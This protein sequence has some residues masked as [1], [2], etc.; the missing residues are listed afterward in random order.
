MTLKVETGNLP[1]DEN[2]EEHELEIYGEEGISS[3]DA[4]FPRWLIIT[5]I[6]LPIWG[7]CT[8]F[9]YFNGSHGWLDPSYWN[10]L[11]KAALTTYLDKGLD[12][13]QVHEGVSRDQDANTQW[14]EQNK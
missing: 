5:Y 2:S 4:R 8:L 11:Q 10:Q 9:Y 14:K 7:F 3:D 12:Q 6:V 13:V 1:V